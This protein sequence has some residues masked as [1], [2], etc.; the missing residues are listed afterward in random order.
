MGWR[1]ER[2]ALVS[3]FPAPAWRRLYHLAISPSVRLPKNSPVALL[4]HASPKSLIKPFQPLILPH[5]TSP[6]SHLKFPYPAPWKISLYSNNSIRSSSLN[7]P[8]NHAIRQLEE[9]LGSWRNSKEKRFWPP[10]TFI[11][12]HPSFRFSKS[13]HLAKKKGNEKRQMRLLKGNS[14]KLTRWL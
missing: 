11:Y 6:P 2:K 8:P 9:F 3:S 12:P 14:S 13:A 5:F 10:N 4:I 1:A 7:L